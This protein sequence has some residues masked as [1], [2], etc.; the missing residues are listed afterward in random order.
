MTRRSLFSVTVAIV[1]SALSCFGQ[2]PPLRFATSIAVPG[3]ARKWDHFAADL[4]KHRLFV[5]SEEDPAVEVIDVRTNKLIKSLRDFKE[6]H[7]VVVFPDMKKLY[8][9]DGGASEIKILNYESYELIGRIQL[10]IDADPYVYDASTKL[11]YVVNGGRQAHTPYCLISVVDV[12]TDKKIVDIKLDTNRLESMTLDKSSSRLFVNMTGINKIGII[13][14]V[15]RLL[16]E[17]WE[18]YAAKENVPMRYDET[19]RR[20]FVATRKP[21]KLVVVDSDTG[22]EIRR[23]D[24]TDYVDDLAYDRTLRRIYVSGGGG[25]GAVD[26]VEQRGPDGYNVVASVPTKPGAKTALFVPEL[27]KYYVG[28]PSRDGQ[29]AEIMVFDVARYH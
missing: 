29:Q 20:L 15:K 9:I 12:K 3:V 26:I 22:K 25:N 7:N 4:E 27:H 24:V 16:S 8:V 14:R 19:D 6:P 21:S 28:V 17:T 13:D 11:L 2:E 1:A 18:I 23:L 5:T 10:A